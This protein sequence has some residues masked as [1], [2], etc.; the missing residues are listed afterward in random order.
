MAVLKSVM[1][2]L[3]A[4]P[5]FL[6]P[7]FASMIILA[8]CRLN[9]ARPE[10]ELIL[11]ESFDEMCGPSPGASFFS[12][13][14]FIPISKGKNYG[15]K[16]EFVGRN[17]PLYLMN[18]RT[19]DSIR[20]I[21]GDWVGENHIDSFLQLHRLFCSKHPFTMVIERGGAFVGIGVRMVEVRREMLGIPVSIKPVAYEVQVEMIRKEEK[22]K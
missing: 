9:S 14:K 2:L 3:R 17:S 10:E 1:L 11:A 20:R 6:V 15:W 18:L 12:T 8:G 7:I 13:S 16:A 19:G 5:V 21:G 4:I 22:K